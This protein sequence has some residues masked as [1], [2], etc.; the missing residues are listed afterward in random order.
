W[1]S[2][3]LARLRKDA[4]QLVALPSDV[5][6]AGAGPAAPTLIQAT[7][8]V[9]IV[10]AQTLD[11]VGAGYVRSMARP[12]GNVTGFSQFEY[13]LSAKWLELL[14]EV[15]P[16][17]ARV[18]LVRETAGGGNIG[19]WAVI[20]AAASP[21]GVELS[22]IDLAEDSTERTLSEFARG[23]NNGLIML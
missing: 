14:R 7:R 21:L 20:A 12:G 4:A 3:D 16:N 5:L 10:L 6:V 8:T 15:A 1:S 2:G 9:P 18:G 11:P 17:V 23:P 13:V 19:Q 22:P